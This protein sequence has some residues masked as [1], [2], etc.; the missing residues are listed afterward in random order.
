[1]DRRK[2]VGVLAKVSAALAAVGATVGIASA[3]GVSG[4][5]GV[6]D[7][8]TAT[9][10]ELTAKRQSLSVD[11]FFADPSPA[12]LEGER[13][14]LKAHAEEMVKTLTRQRQPTEE[15]LVEVKL[16]LIEAEREFGQI[17]GRLADS[18]LTVDQ[19]RKATGVVL[20]EYTRVLEAV[21]RTY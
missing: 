10:K 21:A 11:T 18:Q 5:Q 14:R 4:P 12:R 17:A 8:V 9:L 15:Q 13:A 2:A 16:A 3:Q 1:M 19:A 20:A 6:R 7:P